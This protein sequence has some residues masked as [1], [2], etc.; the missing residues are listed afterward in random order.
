MT[1]K[2]SNN[3]RPARTAPKKSSNTAST[4]SAKETDR[5]RMLGKIKENPKDGNIGK[6]NAG[7]YE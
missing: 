4:S 2:T 6:N 5:K 3:D 1:K 7:G